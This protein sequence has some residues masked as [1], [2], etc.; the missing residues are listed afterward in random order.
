[1]TDIS[2][3]TTKRLPEPIDLW[4]LLG[5]KES[6]PAGIPYLVIVAGLSMTK[7]PDGFIATFYSTIQSGSGDPDIS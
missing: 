5:I 4:A 6:V 2:L 7:V 3:A 1:L